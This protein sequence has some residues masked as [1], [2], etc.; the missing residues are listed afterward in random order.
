MFYEPPKQNHGL[1]HDP[2]K[3]LVVPRP[4]GWI[5]TYDQ[6]GRPNLAPYSFFNAVAS[7]PACVMFSASR[8]ED[9]SAK[10]SQLYAETAGA[11]VVNVVTYA[12]RDAMY[13]TSSPVPRGV[14]EFELAGLEALPG[15]LVN[16][17]RG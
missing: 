17:P 4:I 13:K 5:S 7:D 14:S 16:A 1:P 12:Q 3:A 11:F 15:R 6:H 10:D 8:R 2:F 9:G